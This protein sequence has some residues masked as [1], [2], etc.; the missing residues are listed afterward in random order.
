MKCDSC[1]DR[2]DCM[3]ECD[4]MYDDEESVFDD[5]EYDLAF[6]DYRYLWV[7]EFDDQ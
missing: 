4:F 1:P 2:D 5:E 7:P 3:S 6:D